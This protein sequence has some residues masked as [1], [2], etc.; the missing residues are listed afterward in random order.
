MRYAV[1]FSVYDP[2]HFIHMTHR[3]EDDLGHLF[4]EKAHIQCE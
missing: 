1:R 4:S 3:P 2:T